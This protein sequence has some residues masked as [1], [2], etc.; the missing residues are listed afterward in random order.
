MQAAQGLLLAATS[1]GFGIR[2]NYHGHEPPTVFDRT[3]SIGDSVAAEGFSHWPQEIVVRE[4]T[5][6]FTHTVRNRRIL[7]SMELFAGAALESNDRAKF[8]MAVSA[9]EPLAEQV[10]LGA[11]VSAFVDNAVELL[12]ADLAVPDALRQSIRGRILQL[13]R[14]SVRQALN[15]LCATWFPGNKEAREEIDFLYSLRSEIL[16]EGRVS[17]LD[18]VLSE[19]TNRVSRY[20]RQ[21]YAKEFNVSLRMPTAV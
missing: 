8:V 11:E 12:D 9:L 17:D 2:L 15:R 4:I 10:S 13:R 20:L 6:A 14:E 7:L 1:L 5:D 16:H 18:V 3:V 19:Q 21:I